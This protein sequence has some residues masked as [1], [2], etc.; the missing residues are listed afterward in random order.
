MRTSEMLLTLNL[1]LETELIG[2]QRWNSTEILEVKE[3]SVKRTSEGKLKFIKLVG[4]LI[5]GE[6]GQG[7][8]G[9]PTVRVE[10]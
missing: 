1:Q 2:Y 5:D 4:W 3:I 8:E 9:I 7:D 10:L 6:G